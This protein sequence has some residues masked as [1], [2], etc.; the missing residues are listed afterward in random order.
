MFFNP[1]PIFPVPTPHMPANP[2]AYY[3]IPPQYRHLA[4]L[5]P[6]FQPPVSDKTPVKEVPRV[7]VPRIH[8]YIDAVH[9]RAELIARG[10][11]RGTVD[12][13]MPRSD[14]ERQALVGRLW[15]AMFDLSSPLEA[16]KAQH[17][18][19]I[20]DRTHYRDDVVECNLW[21]LVRAIECAQRGI[22]EIPPWFTTDGPIYKPFDTF[23]ERFEAVEE[24]LK[25]SK[26][27]CCSLFSF[28]EFAARIAWNPFKELKRKQT[29][30]HLNGEKTTIQAVGM[31]DG[32]KF[33]AKAQ[34]PTPY[35]LKTR[36][37]L[38][39]RA[40]P[41]ARAQVTQ[42]LSQPAVR[43][44]L[45][46]ELEALE[47]ESNSPGDSETLQASSNDDDV[48]YALYL[49]TRVH[50]R[51]RGL[52]NQAFHQQMAG[53][54]YPHPHHGLVNPDFQFQ[55]QYNPYAA[56]PKSEYTFDQPGPSQPG[57][58]YQ[59]LADGSMRY[60]KEY[61]TFQQHC[62]SNVAP[63]ASTSQQPQ[64][65][66]YNQQ[67]ANT[68]NTIENAGNYNSPDLSDYPSFA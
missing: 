47:G 14:Y 28:S 52:H 16:E 54:P 1:P 3:A 49:F 68:V 61:D 9:I 60:A 62:S 55:T 25:H 6:P 41:S 7:F 30:H 46:K 56:G 65:Q 27:A 45:E 19:Y 37:G 15:D 36:R 17:Y 64:A 43:K 39:K 53:Y 59:G 44:R 34:T 20:N 58:R 24:A 4:Q 10:N 29:N 42:K 57:P 11:V 21:I 33:A 8:S 26:S 38:R 22:C 48:P 31:E 35:A 32:N 50:R 13:G 66:Q 23:L 51:L 18:K 2:P 63:L 5:A 40:K 12:D 67:D